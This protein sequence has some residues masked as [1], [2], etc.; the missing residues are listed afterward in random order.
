VNTTVG[1]EIFTAALRRR[2]SGTQKKGQVDL[3]EAEEEEEKP[4]H[5]WHGKKGDGHDCL[6]E[7]TSLAERSVQRER[8]CVIRQARRRARK[9]TRERERER[10]LAAR[11]SR[12][13]AHC[14]L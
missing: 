8:V 10:D 2:C 14:L 12:W 1:I 4:R 5:G 13:N 11:L 9:K 7:E 3:E 6:A